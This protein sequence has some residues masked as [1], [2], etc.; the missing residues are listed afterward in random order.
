MLS[1]GMLLVLVFDLMD[2]W[3]LRVEIGL[4]FM[5]AS[6]TLLIFSELSIEDILTANGLIFHI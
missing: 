5:L 3:M 6:S 1:G 4:I 2:V